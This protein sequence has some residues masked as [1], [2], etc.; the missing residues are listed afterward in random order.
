VTR[1][2]VVEDQRDLALGLRAN[3]EVEG[4]TVDVAQTG[5]DALRIASDHR[6]ELVILDIMLPGIDG[7]EVLTKLR[8]MHVDAPV[9]M[10]T[11][12]AEEVDKVRGFRAGADDYVTKP[13]GVMELL[14]RIQALLRRGP[15]RKDDTG[16]TTPVVRVGDVEVDIEGHMVRRNG[17]EIALTP[18]AFELLLAL[19]RKQGKVASRHELLRDIWGYASSVT[20]RTVDAH[21]AELRRKLEADPAEPKHILTVWKVGYRLRL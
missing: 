12:R 13:F 19:H 17:E 15:P 9:L 4:Y 21:V 1:I 7:Y 14:V 11:A 6:P 2:L 3:L 8:A 18:K 10:L 20:T 5:E 16:A